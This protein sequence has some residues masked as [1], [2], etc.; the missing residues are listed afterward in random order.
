MGQEGN[1]PEAPYAA[2]GKRLRRLREAKGLSRSDLAKRLN[3]DVTSLSGWESGKR[4]PRDRTRSL[5]AHALGTDIE[6]YYAPEEDAEAP[7]IA[8]SLTDTH[9]ELP[10]T[11]ADLTRRSRQ[12]LRAFR[13]A[14]P[15]ATTPY[16]QTEWR[17]LV[18]ER[19][20]DGTL[21]VQRIEIFYSLKRLKETLSNIFRYN[22]RRYFVKTY[23]PGLTEIAPFMSGYFFD[24]DEF[25]LGGYWPTTPPV[26]RLPGIRV[27]GSPFRTFFNA[28]WD[29]IWQRGT[30]L[31][32]YAVQDLSTVR[33]VAEKLGLPAGK[34]NEFVE[35]A[36][37]LEVGDGA[38]PL[39]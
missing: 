9:D 7:P 15:Y 2:A 10:G 16:V 34:W 20:L 32:D 22:A 24:D 37:A 4:K 25:I 14:A 23:L 13:F 33:T 17:Q 39:I 27:S 30:L 1:R 18:S 6:S 11:L 8:V 36:K 26:R 12:A 31:N 29:E 38:P 3:A 28:Y 5:L 35:E 21:E 19:I